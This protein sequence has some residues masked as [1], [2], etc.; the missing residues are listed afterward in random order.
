MSAHTIY[1]QFTLTYIHLKNIISVIS[2]P[3]KS[4]LKCMSIFARVL[5]V[6]VPKIWE[7]EQLQPYYSV[8]LTEEPDQICHKLYVSISIMN[9]LKSARAVNFLLAHEFGHFLW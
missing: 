9:T 5:K 1:I 8:R 2:T 7:W 6:A 3:F 4:M